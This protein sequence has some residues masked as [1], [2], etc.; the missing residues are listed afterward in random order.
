MQNENTYKNILIV[1]LD[2]S[3]LNSDLLIESFFS[4][5]RR[6]LRIVPFVLLKSFF[7]RAELDSYLASKAE[8][9]VTELPYNQD[10]INFINRHKE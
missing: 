10:V 4:V 7:N 2:G 5:A 6:D 8:L 9:D 1:D 3:L